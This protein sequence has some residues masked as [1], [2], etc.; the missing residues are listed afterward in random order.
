[1]KE[2]ALG[3]SGHLRIIRSSHVLY[4]ALLGL[5][6]RRCLVENGRTSDAYRPGFASKKQ[7]QRL[8]N[9]VGRWG[10]KGCS[11]TPAS[12]FRILIAFL[13]LSGK[14][15]AQ[16]DSML[17]GPPHNNQQPEP[18]QVERWTQISTD[19]EQLL[20]HGNYAEAMPLAAQAAQMAEATFG[21]NDRKTVTSLN[22]LGD[23]YKHERKYSEAESQY[24]RALSIQEKV[25]G[26]DHVDVAHTLNSLGDL[27]DDE[28]KYAEAEPQYQRAL[29]IREKTLGPDHVD[30]AHTLN[31]LGDLYDDEGKYAEA[32]SQY[33]RALSIREKT[34]GPDHVDVAQTLNNL[35]IS[36]YHDGRYDDAESA[37]VRGMR[38]REKTLGLQHPV[39]ATSLNN[40]AMLYVDE[41]KYREAEP[42]YQR[43]LAIYE[44]AMGPE[45]PRIA[46][47]LTGLGVLYRREG[48]YADAD[49]SYSRA[50][51]IYQKLGGANDMRVARTLHNMASL[52]VF[53]GKY[54]QA[55]TLSLRANA[56]LEKS[57]G[58]DHPDLAIS[59]S[60]L[61]RIYQREG[62]YSQAE[63]FY[64]NALKIWEKSLGAE[65]PHIA[66]VLDDLAGLYHEEGKFTQAEPLY[67]RS[68]VMHEKLE[69]AEHPDVSDTLESFA[70]L[71]F[72][73]Q[74]PNEAQP[75]YSRAFDILFHQFQYNFTYMSERDRLAFLAT[76]TE[77]FPHYYSFVHQYHEQDP[78][79]VGKM[80][81]L[82]LWQKG[83][84]ARSIAAL[85][86][87]IEAGGDP[88]ALNLLDQIA[89]KRGQ[90]SVLLNAQSPDRDAWRKKLEGLEGQADDLE[91]TLVRHSSVYAQ[92]RQLDR[93]TWHDV[94]N[95]LR[96]GESAVEFAN[97]PYFDGKKLT[98]ESYYVALVVTR[99]TKTAPIYI[100]IGEAKQVEGA[101]LAEYQGLLKSRRYK[102]PHGLVSTSPSSYAQ[103]YGV[104]WKPLDQV[105]A[106]K[107]RIYV[108]PDGVFA[109]VPLG[110]L[111][112]PDGHL[113]MEKY[114]L[115]FL[116]STKDLLRE[117]RVLPT[118]TAV[119]IGNPKFDLSA[120]EE[121]VVL[122]KL[123]TE[124][125][126]N[127]EMTGDLSS[128]SLIRGLASED[129]CPNR[130]PGGVLCPL[131]WT[132]KEVSTIQTL[133]QKNGWQVQPPYVGERALKEILRG[134]QHP[135]VLHIATH[136][137]FQPDQKTSKGDQLGGLE[138]SMLRSG[139]LFAGADRFLKGEATAPDLDNGVLT[140]YEASSLDLQGTE[141]VVL[142]ACE[143]GL[144]QIQ[145]GEGVFGLRRALQEAGAES[146]LM[147]MWSV[148]DRETQELMTLFYQ[149]WLSGDDK[150][151]ALREAQMDVR[152]RVKKRY[153]RDIPFYWA[154]F[155]FVGR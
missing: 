103:A 97:F 152:K 149:R 102:D 28:G 145:N 62:K 42:L 144:G 87:E 51:D 120:A 106:G 122:Q 74:L 53:E 21:S 33:Q 147:T 22:T 1:M 4:M 52:Y 115:Q 15:I 29:S 134:V 69:G 90:I 30:V 46:E 67:Q 81:D 63:A 124:Q 110:P 86:R 57:L 137:F 151:V 95:S 111:T 54:S 73:Q 116:F 146:V 105:L 89:A 26:P 128:Q 32:E 150:P 126:P 76:V 132:E 39:T 14:L 36:Y 55:E 12:S 84:I 6:A 130:P 20:N 66:A 3:A 98:G 61:A 129:N 83:F 45:H 140:A 31:S 154:G 112:G 100:V 108:S 125:T 65:H 104:L 49:A 19:V 56:I 79:L 77:R 142:S 71:R 118:K 131:P 121:R 148:P 75:L 35:G 133:L 40:L 13:L 88:E 9:R 34:L 138:D 113:L 27:Y 18:A 64:L 139:L 136:G 5:S 16:A 10:D 58:P 99:E 48:R 37:Y 78:E 96:P 123:P 141:L 101:P 117:R 50:L 143:T 2:R 60:N 107:R 68:L 93:V 25:L 92:Q 80:Y 47:S 82:L 59:L 7:C 114:D 41:G 91:K 11:S 8:A 43:V 153:G 85:R 72:A 17:P 38:I 155:V 94:S 109:Q 24:Q 135:R 23:V 70:S 127:R 119:L 44:K